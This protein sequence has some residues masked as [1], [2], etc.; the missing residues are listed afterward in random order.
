MRR[1]REGFL[2]GM[3][4]GL[5]VVVVLV[6]SVS[7]PGAGVVGASS[8]GFPTWMRRGFIGRLLRGW[9]LWV[10][11]RGRSALRASSVQIVTVEGTD[12]EGITIRLP[13]PPQDLPTA[14]C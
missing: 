9:R 1:G 13:A 4:W 8:E 7:G 3:L 12:I 6:G 2:P 14:Q 11:S 5:G 10:C